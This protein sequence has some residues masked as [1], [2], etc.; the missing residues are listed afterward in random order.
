MLKRVEG[1]RWKIV[2][3]ESEG[4]GLCYVDGIGDEDIK[5]VELAVRA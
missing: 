2:V 3:R 4:L 1:R 5:D